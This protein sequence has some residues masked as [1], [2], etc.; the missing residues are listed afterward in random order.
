MLHLALTGMNRSF[1]GKGEEKEHL[2]TDGYTKAWRCGKAER[3]LGELY[4]ATIAV[5]EWAV[6]LR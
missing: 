5:Q 6:S 3:W 2:R 1:A 4:E